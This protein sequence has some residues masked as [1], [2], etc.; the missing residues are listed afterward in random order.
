MFIELLRFDGSLTTKCMSLNNELCMTRPTLVDLNF[1]KF[2]YFSFMIGLDKYSESCNN[3]VD[4]L[5][6]KVCILSKTEGIKY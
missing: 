5:S 1:V 3:A 2:N 6:S 4:G